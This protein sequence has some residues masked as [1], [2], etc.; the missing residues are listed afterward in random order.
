MFTVINCQTITVK[1]QQIWNITVFYCKLTVCNVKYDFLLLYVIKMTYRNMTIL[2][3][4]KEKQLS[5]VN[6][7]LNF[8]WYYGKMTL[9]LL[10]SR[11]MTDAFKYYSVL[12]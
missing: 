10:T 9:V 5:A 12:L 3:C 11:T 7:A 2:Y 6:L 8:F 4:K 1:D